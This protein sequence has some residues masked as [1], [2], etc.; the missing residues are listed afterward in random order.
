MSLRHPLFPILVA[1]LSACSNDDSTGSAGLIELSVTPGA[2]S[3]SQGTNGSV[4]ISLT[5]SSGFTE[6]VSLAVT[7]LPAGIITT[8]TPN[9]L[10]GARA[11]A[12]VTDR[13]STRL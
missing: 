12:V 10:V 9:E 8:V 11:T 1:A 3:V 6:P 7:G 4:N 5:R 2:I 13:Q